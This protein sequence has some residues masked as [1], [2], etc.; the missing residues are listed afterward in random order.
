MEKESF[1]QTL[2]FLLKVKS[3]GSSPS[4]DISTTQDNPPTLDQLLDLSTKELL[5]NGYCLFATTD[6]KVIACWDKTPKNR[7]Q[8]VIQKLNKKNANK[9][10]HVVRTSQSCLQLVFAI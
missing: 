1:F 3:L 8:S 6:N 7:T 2:P 10:V 9:F 4:S 5:L